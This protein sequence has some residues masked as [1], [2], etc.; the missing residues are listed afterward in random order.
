MNVIALAC[1]GKIRDGE[2]IYALL[3]Q[4]PLYNAEKSNGMK[5]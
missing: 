2:K 3:M 5:A 4:T 1:I